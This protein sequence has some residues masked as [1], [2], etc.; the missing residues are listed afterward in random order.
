MPRVIIENPNLFM[1]RI[2][3]VKMQ[4]QGILRG[5][6]DNFWA[7]FQV[8]KGKSKRVSVA[9]AKKRFQSRFID[10]FD[11]A[12]ECLKSQNFSEIDWIDFRDVVD[13]CHYK[14]VD[15]W[16]LTEK[17]LKALKK[18]DI[19]IEVYS[20]DDKHFRDTL[21]RLQMGL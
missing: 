5:R 19:V 13:A 9:T 7:S 11:E 14:I 18:S 6:Y 8:V 3:R 16:G 10:R 20:R 2:E 1:S 4:A 21:R 17:Q 12:L 15:S